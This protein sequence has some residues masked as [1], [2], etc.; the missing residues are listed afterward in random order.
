VFKGAGVPYCCYI[1]T[2][3]LH[4][5]PNTQVQAKEPQRA[6]PGEDSKDLQLKAWSISQVNCADDLDDSSERACDLE[7][8]KTGP[9]YMNSEI[10][11]L[12][13][14]AEEGKKEPGEVSA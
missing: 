5:T 13:G 3:I 14:K 8:G 12:A 2:I 4:E 11:K 6:S 9:Y 7:G 1:L 10:Q